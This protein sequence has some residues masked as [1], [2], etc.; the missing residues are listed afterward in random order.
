[1][2]ISVLLALLEKTLHL[3]WIY[4]ETTEEE[5]AINVDKT[6]VS[7]ENIVVPPPVEELD[8]LYHL[9]MSGDMDEIQSQADHLERLDQQYIPFASKLRTFAHNFQ[10]DQLL[11]FVEQY[12]KSPDLEA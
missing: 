1:V 5:P 7:Y 10:D 2:E 3:E 12:R 11:A 8:R 6:L 4:K 9:A